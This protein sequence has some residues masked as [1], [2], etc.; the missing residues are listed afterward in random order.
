VTILPEERQKT[1]RLALALLPLLGF[2]GLGILF[3]FRLFAGDPG[4]LP[5]A[6]ILKP[7]PVFELAPLDGLTR[8]GAP[9]PGFSQTDLAGGSVAG[10]VALV[11]VFASWCVPCREE[12]ALLMEIA[13]DPRIRLYGLNYKDEAENARRFLGGFGNPYAAVGVDRSGRVGI[14]WGVY[15]VPE[16]FLVRADGR[17]A[18]KWVG[19]IT[20]E[21]VK[22]E[23]M[24]EVTKALGE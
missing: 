16:T 20:P 17:I 2:L 8:A 6:L 9:V 19:A 11:N 22:A 23:V 12:H 18:R 14:D 4:T 24:P 5:S 13:K 10:R 3:S 15:G 21:I 1:K 7:V